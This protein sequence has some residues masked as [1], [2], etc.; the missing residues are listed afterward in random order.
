[1]SPVMIPGSGR[2]KRRNA[3][4]TDTIMNKA[5]TVFFTMLLALYCLQSA[6]AGEYISVPLDDPVYQVLES[7]QIRGLIDRLP[8]AKPYSSKTVYTALRQLLDHRQQLSETETAIIE[9]YLEQHDREQ[10]EEASIFSSGALFTDSQCLRAD[11][12]A[13]V[14]SLN[15]VA[16]DGSGFPYGTIDFLNLYLNGDMGENLPIEDP[17]LSYRFDMGFGAVSIAGQ[18]YVG[19]KL[20]TLNQEAFAPYT[21][22]PAW[23]GYSFSLFDPFNNVSEMEEYYI[24]FSMDPEISAQLFVDHLGLSLSRISRNW[25]L[26]EDS[27]ILS[28]QASPFVSF[29]MDAKIFDW[30]GY[31][32]LVGALEN[33]GDSFASSALQNMVTMRTVDVRPTKWLYVG[34]HEAVIWPKRLELGYLNPL[35]FSSLY[36]GMIGN[37][38]NI[39]GGMSFGLSIPRYADFYGTFFI[40]EF[41]LVSFSD[42]FERVRNFYSCQAGVKVAIPGTNFGTLTIQYTKIEPFAYTHPLT[43]VPWVESETDDNG[44]V[45]ESFVNSGDGLCSKLDPNSDE[46]LVKFESMITPDITLRGAYQ[47]IRHGEYGGDYNKPLESYSDSDDENGILPDGMEYP[48]WLDGAEVTDVNNVNTLKKSFLHDGNYD[49]YHI[50][51]LGGSVDMRRTFGLPIKLKVTNSF[52]YQFTTDEHVDLV[53]DSKSYTNYMTVALQVWGE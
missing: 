17:V 30:M 15:G 33:S 28:G 23:A 40:D 2:Y 7:A 4:P 48:D 13:W 21:F 20:T 18:D 27:L 39:L 34:V 50:I 26:G 11:M 47:M 8:S 49:W 24:A 41:N 37:Y 1:M 43:E 6:A 53:D 44:Y 22:T 36:Q 19:I 35:I 16:V 45:Y 9:Q 10:R 25:G 12:G 31:S 52:V 38:D 42:M 14:E 51:A 5:Y 29:S 46:L 3:R 32:F